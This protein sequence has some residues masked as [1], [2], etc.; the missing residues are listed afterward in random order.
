MR[1]ARDTHFLETAEGLVGTRK[2]RNLARNT[3]VLE[4]AKGMLCQGK[5]RE[6]PSEGYSLSGDGR[7]R[8]QDLSGQKATER[9]ALTLWRW[10]T[11]GLVRTRKESDERGVLTLWRW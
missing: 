9:G 4:M 6:R 5:E 1:R 2:E 8:S 7:W 10:K 11:R 3:H